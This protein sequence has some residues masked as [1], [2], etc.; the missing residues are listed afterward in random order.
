MFES[1]PDSAMTDDI[2]NLIIE[3]IKKDIRS[4]RWDSLAHCAS[5]KTAMLV[6][7]DYL[8]IFPK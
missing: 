5:F 7:I 8:S 3:Q 1:R 2:D 4:E 6:I